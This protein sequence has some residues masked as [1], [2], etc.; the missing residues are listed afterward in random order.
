MLRSIFGKGRAVLPTSEDDASSKAESE[1]S[2][3]PEEHVEGGLVDKDHSRSR[4]GYA[5]NR[6]S[7]LGRRA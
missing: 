1:A 5:K 6:S 2:S 3:K 4:R 7:G